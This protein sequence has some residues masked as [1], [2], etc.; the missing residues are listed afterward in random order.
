MPTRVVSQPKCEVVSLAEAKLHLRVTHDLEDIKIAS[1]LR[2][3]REHAE[4]ITQRAIGRQVIELSCEAFPHGG[5]SIRL[6]RPP[7][8]A[9][10]SVM[11]RDVDGAW[12]LMLPA[13][14]ELVH[15]GDADSQLVLARTLSSWPQTMRPALQA[16]R[17]T[18]VAGY[19]EQNVPREIVEFMLLHLGTLFEHRESM[20]TGTIA[21][22]LKHSERLLDRMR[23]VG[24]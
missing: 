15:L 18:Y 5:L 10:T 17:V 4:H 9:V 19:S 24:E 21:T 2:A 12:Q 7:V 6:P 20:V 16:V 3:A 13:D 11:Y 22:E 14:Y 23:V 1:A 8:V